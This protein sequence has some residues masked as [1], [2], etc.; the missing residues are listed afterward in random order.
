MA[1]NDSDNSLMGSPLTAQQWEGLAKLGNLGNQLD[2]LFGS[3]SPFSGP[4]TGVIE[5]IGQLDSRYDFLALTEKTLNFAKQLDEAGIFDLVAHNAQ[6]VSDSLQVVTPILSQWMDNIGTVSID[7]YKEDLCFILKIVRKVRYLGEFYE[8]HLAGEVTGRVV[9]VTE[10][11]EV[12]R[13]DEALVSLLV[14]MGRIYRS[15]LLEKI[16]ELAEMVAGLEEGTSYESFVGSM[17]SSCSHEKWLEWKQIIQNALGSFNEEMAHPS[18]G[19]LFSLLGLLK[20]PD[21]QRVIKALIKALGAVQKEF[22]K[23]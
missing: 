12:N 17:V 19:G 11:M 13:T 21:V 4:L 3:E 5:H 20:D 22:N 6:F 7:Q 18:S 2:A 1:T 9:Q 15:G 14:L 16:G 10:F 8:Q 23:T